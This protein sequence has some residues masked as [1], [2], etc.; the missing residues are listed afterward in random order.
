MENITN[1][2]SKTNLRAK[3]TDKGGYALGAAVETNLHAL[4]QSF[5]QTVGTLGVEPTFDNWMR[6][7]QYLDD[8]NA[9]EE[10]RFI[11]VR[12]ATYY[13][14]R[15]IDQFVNADYTGSLG[16]MKTGRS[17]VGTLWGNVPVF[18]TTLVRA[19]SAG[20]AENWYCHKRGVY[21]CSQ[22][23][24]SRSAF[25]IN[26]DSDIVSLTHIYGYLEALQPPITAGGGA[27]TDVFNVVVY[28]VS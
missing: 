11:V 24:K 21:Y 7:S 23:M 17:Q 19:P 18:K 10:D 22:D 12:P 28:G 3:Y 4:P 27:A 2:Q 13:A 20:Q 6:A 14:M 5:S 16:S 26:M 9:P 8:A 15:K 25:D 1:V